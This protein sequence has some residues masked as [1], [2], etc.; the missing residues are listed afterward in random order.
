MPDGRSGS[1]THPRANEPGV[2]DVKVA[3]VM[4]EA[5]VDVVNLTPTVKEQLIKM[6][7]CERGARGLTDSFLACHFTR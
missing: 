5:E 2:D 3:E 7:S 4:L 6:E 1:I